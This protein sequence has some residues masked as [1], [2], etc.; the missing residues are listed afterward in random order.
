MSQLKNN[1][2]GFIPLLVVIIIVV[3][4]IIYFAYIRVHQVAH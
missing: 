4:L 2:C 3:A 1:Q